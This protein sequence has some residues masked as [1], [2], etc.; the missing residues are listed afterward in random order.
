MDDRKREV[1]K[2]AHKGGRKT[3]SQVNLMNYE[4]FI[5]VFGNVIEHCSLCAAAVWKH[6]P[7]R[8]VNHLYEE[9]C[10][11]VDD[12][13]ESGNLDATIAVCK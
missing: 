12:L 9:I 7:F 10:R 13:T 2:M 6:R 4:E 11:F 5:E 8:D 1:S 3:L